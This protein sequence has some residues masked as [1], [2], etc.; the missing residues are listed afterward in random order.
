[1]GSYT[2]REIVRVI[3]YILREGSFG[4]PTGFCVMSVTPFVGSIERRV[5]EMG[6]AVHA[7]K[8]LPAPFAAMFAESKAFE[9]RMDDRN[10]RVGDVLRLREWRP[11]EVGDG[12]SG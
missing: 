12:R 10:F 2:G 1:M 4:V 7:L 5:A 9:Y 11:E 8:T 6:C 3:T